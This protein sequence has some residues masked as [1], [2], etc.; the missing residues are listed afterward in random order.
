MTHPALVASGLKKSFQTGRK[1]TTV[2]AGVDLSIYAG[3]LSLIMGPSG[4]GKSTL[5]AAM[6]GLLR[7]DEGKV[8]AKGTDL[9]SLSSKQLDRFRL[10][11]FGFVFQ[12]FNL[13]AS[14]TARQQIEIVLKYGG[15]DSREATARADQAL[16][17]VG[18]AKRADLRPLELSG[19]EKQRTAIARAL[20]KEPKFLF[21]D[22]P[23]SALDSENGQTV[24]KLLRKAA[25]EHEALVLCVTHDARLV[26]YADRLIRIEDGHILSDER[27]NAHPLTKSELK[28]AE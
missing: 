3:E 10:I 1:S 21:A 16:A 8:I 4:S 19:G 5:L 12:G 11:N 6:S 17:E 2:L 7:P 26:E 13:F 28:A 25:Y 27:F 22:E 24:I 14:L 9:W 23:T 18:L 20:A 15:Y